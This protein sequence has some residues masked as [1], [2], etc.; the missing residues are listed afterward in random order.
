MRSVIQKNS[1]CLI[2]G[3]KFGLHKHHVFEGS[4]NRKTSEKYGMTVWLVGEWHNLSTKGVHFNK[5][6]DDGLKDYAQRRFIELWSMEEW[7]EAFHK[8][9]LLDEP[10]FK[11]LE[12]FRRY[13]ER[14][15]ACRNG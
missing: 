6:L 3:A 4:A 10:R 2:T 8:N 11:T 12:D 14:Y 1:E 7:M 5:Y 13:G 9:Y 15:E